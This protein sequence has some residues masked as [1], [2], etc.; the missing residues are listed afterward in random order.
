MVPIGTMPFVPLVGNNVKPVPLQT[1]VVMVVT[2]GL[3]FTVT[4]MVKATPIQ[5]PVVGVTM[6]IA[7]WAA[8][9]GFT[10][11]PLMLEPLPLAPPVNPPVT[12][13]VDQL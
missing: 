6:Y 2:A 9:V 5:D 12:V 11:F 13:G 10:R 4:V 7:V 3:G 1:V 8:F